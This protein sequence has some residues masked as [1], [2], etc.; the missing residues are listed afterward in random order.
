M[1]TRIYKV[2]TV[3]RCDNGASAIIVTDLIRAISQAQAERHA[4]KSIIVAK[5]ATQEELV[6]MMGAGAK[7]LD[8]T[9]DGQPTQLPL[10]GV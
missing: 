1:K 10:G 6:A 5:V 2:D 3:R 9:K 8:A 4:S 7:V